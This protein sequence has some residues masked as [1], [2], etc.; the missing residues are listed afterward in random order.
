MSVEDRIETPPPSASVVGHALTNKSLFR[1]DQEVLQGF[2]GIHTVERRVHKVPII[3]YACL[4]NW[5]PL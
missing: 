4:C 5:H 2:P 3:G 1:G